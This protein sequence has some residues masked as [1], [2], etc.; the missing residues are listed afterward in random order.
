MTKGG[1]FACGARGH[2]RADV[3]LRILADDA[4]HEECDPWAALGQGQV[5]QRRLG[6][7]AKDRA[8]LG[9]RRHMHVLLRRGIALPPWLGETMLGLC[10]LLA[11]P[12]AL[13]TLAHLG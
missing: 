7:L 5:V 2:H 1:S 6:T 10:H 8:A 12:L 3:H 11:S 9:Q 13:L 4:L